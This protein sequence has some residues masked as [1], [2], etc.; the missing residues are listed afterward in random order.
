MLR[1]YIM[2]LFHPFLCTD[3]LYPTHRE[4]FHA[5]QWMIMHADQSAIVWMPQNNKHLCEFCDTHAQHKHFEP[6][7]GPQCLKP[8]ATTPKSPIQPQCL[9]Y[10]TTTLSM[11]A[12]IQWPNTDV[13]SPLCVDGGRLNGSR[14]K[15]GRLEGG[16]L[17]GGELEADTYQL[18]F[19][20]GNSNR[21][22]GSG[23]DSGG[24]DMNHCALQ[25]I[26]SIWHMLYVQRLI[27]LGLSRMSMYSYLQIYNS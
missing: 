7:S 6:N 20:Q 11:R 16:E 10:A 26:F 4:L 12:T 3:H 17:D 15:N 23:L 9:K 14:L 18:W 24:L 2:N 22:D 8:N 5:Q 21:L 19:A 25:A 27:L 1:W 13:S